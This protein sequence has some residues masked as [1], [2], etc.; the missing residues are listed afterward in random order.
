MTT[1]GSLVLV[2]PILAADPIL[3]AVAAF[4]LAADP[5]LVVVAAS[6]LAAVPILV[7]VACLRLTQHRSSG[8]I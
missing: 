4:R 6:H 1:I 8:K 3:A 5:I 2:V 7:V